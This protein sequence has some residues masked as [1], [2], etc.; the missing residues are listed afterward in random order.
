MGKDDIWPIR[1]GMFNYI[2]RPLLKVRVLSMLAY[3][4]RHMGN[5]TLHYNI[6]IRTENTGLINIIKLQIK[7]N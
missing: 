3:L 4:F 1:T 6:T 7:N 5:A 2:R